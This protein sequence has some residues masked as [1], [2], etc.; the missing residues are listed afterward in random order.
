MTNSFKFSIICVKV[1]QD[2]RQ[3]MIKKTDTT[4]KASLILISIIVGLILILSIFFWQK[5]RRIHSYFQK[6]KNIYFLLIGT[7]K[8]KHK[9]RTDTIIVAVFNTKTKRLGLILIPRDIKVKINNLYYGK[10]N[11]LYP[12]KGLNALKSYLRIT[13]G[14]PINF[15]A[16]VDL[17]GFQKMIDLIGGVDIFNEKRLKYID[18]A[19]QVYIDLPPGEIHLDGLKA[20][21]FIRF[22]KDERGDFGRLERQLAVL[23]VLLKKILTDKTIIKNL[24]VLKI[25][26]RYVKTNIT[27]SDIL[28]LLKY[29]SEFNLYNIT[30]MR[31]P[32]KFENTATGN[33]IVIDKNLA[34]SRVKTFVNNLDAILPEFNP[35]LV[36]V[37]VLNGTDIPGLAAKARNRLL[38][39]GYNVVEF[40]NADRN[41]YKKSYVFDRSGHLNYAKHVADILKIKNT[42]PNINKLL[43]LDTTVILGQDYADRLKKK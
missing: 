15:Y 35:S 17:T 27:L 3:K 26:L 30:T 22:R 1:I 14:L 43:V 25:L 18:H 6:E 24:D 5:G 21:E 16:V 39:F 33:Y 38:Y 32:G 7:D 13:F 19:G 41:N 12:A 4:D 11:S 20:M 8:E 2:T 37:Q 23:Q 28:S 29:E 40:G 36:T 10:I 9:G 34:A 42:Y 31:I